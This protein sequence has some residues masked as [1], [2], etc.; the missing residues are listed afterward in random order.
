M[1][2]ACTDGN[3][4]RALTVSGFLR[5]LTEDELAR[6][7]LQDGNGLAYPEA[8]AD[9]YQVTAAALGR[10]PQPRLHLRERLEATVK[11]FLTVRT[12]GDRSISRSGRRRSVPVGPSR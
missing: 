10:P 4:D 11:R 5:Y 6:V 9:L 3:D 8:L 2:S 12:E 7:R 1:A